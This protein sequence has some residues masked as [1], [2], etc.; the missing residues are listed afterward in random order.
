MRKKAK[1]FEQTLE[2]LNLA[3]RRSQAKC[4]LVETSYIERIKLFL[5]SHTISILLIDLSRSVW[6]NL[7]LRRVYRPHCVR[8]VLTTSVKILLYRPPA[9]FIRAL[10]NKWALLKQQQQK[11]IMRKTCTCAGNT[12]YIVL[13]I[14]LWS[15]TRFL[16]LFD[17]IQFPFWIVTHFDDS[18]A[19]SRLSVVGSKKK[20][21]RE[22]KWGRSF[23]LLP[24]YREPGTGER[25]IR[26]LTKQKRRRD[27]Y[28]VPYYGP[29]IWIM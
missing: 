14:L 6:E 23:S 5:F 24:N 29:V 27:D 22:K 9:R 21:E 17:D 16:I 12:K 15:F 20:W 26:E 1:G 8:S 4:Q 28:D 25:F 10:N 2:E 3:Y 18:L 19:C 13:I 11:K 7:N